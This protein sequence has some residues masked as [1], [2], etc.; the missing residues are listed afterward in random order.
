MTSATNPENGTVS[1]AYNVDGTLASKTDANGNTES[2]YCD[3]YQRLTS[4]PDRQQT[5]THDTCPTSST[6]FVVGCVGAAGQLTQAT[7]GRGIGTNEL[8]FKYNYAYT[9]TG[10]ASSETLEVQSAS[11]PSTWN[12]QAYGAL[13]ASHDY[14]S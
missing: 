2:Y 12:V 10:K 9:P 4:I 13:A 11:N 3:G 7:F 14:D 6:T 8:N 1:Y 5:F